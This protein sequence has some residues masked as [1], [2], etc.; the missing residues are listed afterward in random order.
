VELY[1]KDRAEKGF[2]VIQAV[3]LAELDGNETANSYGQ[4]PLI[5]N[6]PLRPNE[7]YFKYV[8]WVIEKAREYRIYIAALPTWGDKWNLKW[9]KGPLIF[10]D[11]QTS[12]KY[13][14][15]LATRYK[16]QPNIIWVLGGDR[17]PETPQHL[18]IIRAMAKGLQKG[19]HKKHLIT[20]H[21]MGGV[22]SSKWFHKDGWLA[23][24]MTQTGHWRRHEKVYQAV[25][26]DYQLNP[27]KPNINGE[28]QYED[29]PVRFTNENER[30]TAYDTR[31]AA[32]WSILSGA[33]GHTYGNNNIWQMWT[34]QREP[35]I[36][37]RLSWKIAIHQP[38]A[39]QMGY[40]RKVFEA[41]PF[42][43]LIP[44]QQI[45]SDYFGQDYDNIRTAGGRDGSYI[46]A[47]LPQGQTARLRM[48][49]LKA[50]TVCGWWYNPREGV[51]KKI[52]PFANPKTDMDFTPVSHGERTDWVL[53]LDDAAKR[54]P[55]PAKMKF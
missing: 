3:I 5:E 20:F 54:Y 41:R 17:N 35:I 53:I 12:E 9:G 32:Y 10:K 31:E 40:L 46:I 26:A 24:N 21:P 30:F 37:A 13:C 44:D 4:K 22:S 28:P 11:T 45:L 1:F 15:W 51:S 47:Y 2:N 25:S 14:Q 18:E 7:E 55:D 34:P 27:P 39:A 38:G 19:D 6:D 43:E 52:D 8:D 49:K 23:F 50:D 29:I 33:L 42:L 16:D 36:Y 48:Q